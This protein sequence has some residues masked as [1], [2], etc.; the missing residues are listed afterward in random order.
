MARRAGEPTAKPAKVDEADD[1]EEEE[2]PL[3]RRKEELVVALKEARSRGDARAERV[4]R[5]EMVTLCADFEAKN[6]KLLRRLPPE[7]WQKILDENLHQNDLFALS[8]TCRFFRDTT[9]DLGKKVETNLNATHLLELRKSGKVASH[10]L[11]WFQ[12]V[13]DTMEILQG[14]N[15]LLYAR[16]K[17]AVYE[18]DLVNY[19]AFQGSV[20]ILRWLMEEKGW[21]LNDDTGRWAGWGGSVEILKY[22]WDW[23][24][25][26]DEEVCQWAAFGGHLEALKFLR[27]LDPPC[28]WDE[29]TCSGAAEGG[30]LEVLKWARSQDP[31]CP[32]GEGTCSEAAEGGHLEVLKWLR[33]EEPPCPW[34]RSG[35]RWDASE[36]GHHHIVKWI[37]QQEDVSD[38]ESSDSDSDS[39]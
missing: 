30:H 28:P 35:Y 7:L 4:A 16:V 23:G 24:Y 29:E 11:G 18:S 9:K 13:C 3:V 31:P 33:A 2:D 26:F 10:T 5:R 22:L 27:G 8:M 38:V 19:A 36:N 6:E 32:W 12:W 17:G 37:D 25:E 14:F 39:Y 21:E 15:W 34:S 1:E 20:E